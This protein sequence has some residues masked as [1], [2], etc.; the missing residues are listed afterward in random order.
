MSSPMQKA[1]VNDTSSS[2]RHSI[3]MIVDQ[4][5]NEMKQLADDFGFIYARDSMCGFIA[6]ALAVHSEECK[7]D[8]AP[9]GIINIL[10]QEVLPW[11]VD[12]RQAY[13]DQH[14]DEFVPHGT[15][16]QESQGRMSIQTYKGMMCSTVE[17]AQ[18][19]SLEKWMVLRQDGND[20]CCC[21][22]LLRNILEG[23][24][25]D[26]ETSIRFPRQEGSFIAQE[27]LEYLQ[28]ERQFWTSGADQYVQVADTFMSVQDLSELVIGTANKQWNV[29]IDSNSHYHV[30]RISFDRSRNANSGNND[31]QQ[32]NI[33]V[34]EEFDSMKRDKDYK[35]HPC[36]NLVFALQQAWQK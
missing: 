5:C 30:L 22:A 32:R 25:I 36:E 13:I 18:Y 29:I 34:L 3:S 2:I 9:G 31:E 26:A 10:Q 27:E 11:M 33:M 4:H 8:M 20:Y 28:H 23:P 21:F 7:I 1:D 12:R 16:Y 35:S 24:P 15:P 6:M 14:E 17:I 19:L